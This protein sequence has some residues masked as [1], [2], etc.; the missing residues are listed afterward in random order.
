V[1][2]GS[3][4]ARRSCPSR[5]DES[6]IQWRY[7]RSAQEQRVWVGLPRNL[8]DP[9]GPGEERGYINVLKPRSEDEGRGRTA[10]ADKQMKGDIIEF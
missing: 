9:R 5:V 2:I 4:E 10:V 3:A 7:P 1:V 8:K 6:V